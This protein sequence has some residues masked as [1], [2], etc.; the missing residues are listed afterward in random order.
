MIKRERNTGREF[1]QRRAD[2]KLAAEVVSVMVAPLR[3]RS[4]LPRDEYSMLRNQTQAI[5][6]ANGRHFRGD[7]AT[8]RELRDYAS[9]SPYYNAAK[10]SHDTMSRDRS[11]DAV[12]AT[13]SHR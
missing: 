4:I 5:I 8:N 13:A 3:V 11:R 9:R 12:N 10:R 7:I 6:Q 1:D 2:L